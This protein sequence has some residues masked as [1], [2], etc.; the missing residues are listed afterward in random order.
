MNKGEKH[1]KSDAHSISFNKKG[2]LLSQFSEAGA[3]YMPRAKA[4]ANIGS[5]TLLLRKNLAIFPTQ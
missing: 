1:W 2:I 4:R 3:K 5:L